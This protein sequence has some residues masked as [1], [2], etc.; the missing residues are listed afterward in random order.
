[1]NYYYSLATL[2]STQPAP[3]RHASAGAAAAPRRPPAPLPGGWREEVKKTGLARQASQQQSQFSKP[4]AAVQQQLANRAAAPF[5]FIQSSQSPRRLEEHI[6]LWGMA[7]YDNTA[8]FMSKINHIMLL[9]LTLFI[10]GF[11]INC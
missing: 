11:C 1:M 3:V 2:A 9:K 6:V 5:Y 7:L 10:V 4:A 8:T